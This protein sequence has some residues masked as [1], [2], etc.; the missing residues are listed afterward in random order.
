MVLQ[1]CG[2]GKG[3]LS[4][5][6]T[7]ALSRSSN[8]NP[9]AEAPQGGLNRGLSAGSNAAHTQAPGGSCAHAFGNEWQL[10]DTPC[11]TKLAEQ[12]LWSHTAG[13]VRLFPTLQAPGDAVASP[14]YML[15]KGRLGNY[16]PPSHQPL[17]KKS[18]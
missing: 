16:S 2:A 11:G 5:N 8:L 15:V 10:L 14:K 12:V 3:G 1:L 18:T 4:S 9:P 13:R 7:L 6:A 17:K